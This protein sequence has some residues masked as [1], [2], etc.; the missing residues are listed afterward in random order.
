MHVH[1]EIGFFFIGTRDL[2][3]LGI[4]RIRFMLVVFRDVSLRE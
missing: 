3:L 4:F 2:N 1:I